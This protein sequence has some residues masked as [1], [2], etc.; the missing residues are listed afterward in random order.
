[1][2]SFMLCELLASAKAS[3]TDID[4]I[5]CVT[6]RISAFYTSGMRQIALTAVTL[7]L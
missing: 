7:N 6:E 2:T 1:M 3:G 4:A 5:S